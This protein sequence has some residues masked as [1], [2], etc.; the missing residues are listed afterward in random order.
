MNLFRPQ[1]R[2][3]SKRVDNVKRIVIMMFR[4]RPFGQKMKKLIK[5]T[6]QCLQDGGYPRFFNNASSLEMFRRNI[7]SLS[8][9][10][11]RTADGTESGDLPD[12]AE[13]PGRILGHFC[14]VSWGV[15]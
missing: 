13:C 2:R 14:T 5:P 10:T 1:R 15:G 9:I 11:S 7:S 3:N 8:G 4:I 12:A 6:D